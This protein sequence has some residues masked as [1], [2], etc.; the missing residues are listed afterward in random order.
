MN[1]AHFKVWMTVFALAS[2]SPVVT[3]QENETPT[4]PITPEIF[5]DEPFAASEGIAFNGEGRMFVSAN[6]AVWEVRPDRTVVKLFDM[7]SNLGLAAYGPRDVLAADFG[8][9]NAFRHDRNSDGVV[10]RTNPE[11]EKQA[12]A[13]GIGDPNAIVVRPDGSFIVSD[14]ATAD[15]YSVSPEG[16]VSL[17]STA[18]SHPNGLLISDDGLTLYVARIFHSIRP[19]VFDNSV[20]AIRLNK[21][22]TPHHSEPRLVFR[23]DPGGGN[24]GLAMDTR[25]RLYVST[26]RTGKI[27][28]YDPEL[29]ETV[30]VAEGMPGAAGL[31]FGKGEF[32]HHSIYVATTFSEGRGGKIYRV[33]VGIGGRN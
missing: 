20:W 11:G 7:D 13:T 16:E 14:D 8:P 24:D 26:P 33:P 5:V 18:V 15:I 31:A 19:V 1:T 23:T 17:F 9:T 27:W 2:S 32:D 29:D 25:G 30:L 10:W 28:R 3:A 4:L 12:L 21:D 22:G 6:K